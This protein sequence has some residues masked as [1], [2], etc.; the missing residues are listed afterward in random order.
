MKDSRIVFIRKE[1]ITALE[2]LK[3]LSPEQ[4]DNSNATVEE[5]SNY[6]L[7]LTQTFSNIDM[8]VLERIRVLREL[9]EGIN[10]RK[11]NSKEY[12]LIIKI[13][14]LILSYYDEELI[15]LKGLSDIINK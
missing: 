11:D 12:V 2:L 5:F 6:I 10:L 4:M 9:K 8:N 13:L 1:A 7:E 3:G 14:D 15:F